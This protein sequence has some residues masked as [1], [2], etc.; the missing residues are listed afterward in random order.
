[1]KTQCVYSK[2]L[3]SARKTTNKHGVITG[4]AA[5]GVCLKSRFIA[6]STMRGKHVIVRSLAWGL[7]GSVFRFSE[8]AGAQSQALGQL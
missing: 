5:R 6:S 1:M 2:S 7:N 3:A 8:R 4:L